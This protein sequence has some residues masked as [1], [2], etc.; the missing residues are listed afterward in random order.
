MST[1]GRVNVTSEFQKHGNK[2]IMS[3]SSNT[4]ALNK[5]Y[6]MYVNVHNFGTTLG[7]WEAR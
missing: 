1:Y 7:I 3:Q 5:F 6:Y 2:L 4:Y